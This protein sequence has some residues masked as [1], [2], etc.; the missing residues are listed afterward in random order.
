MVSYCW[1]LGLVI[2]VWLS[3]HACGHTRVYAM[4]VCVSPSP[5]PLSSPVPRSLMCSASYVEFGEAKTLPQFFKFTA[6]N[7]LSVKTKV[8]VV[9]VRAGWG[10]GRRGGMREEQ[11][12]GCGFARVR[13]R[14]ASRAL[15][16][17]AR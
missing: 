2:R 12:P 6:A 10:R 16:V 5:P 3:A 9:K 7:P 4:H 13:V 11:R 8:R 1:T 14:M 15:Q 17:A